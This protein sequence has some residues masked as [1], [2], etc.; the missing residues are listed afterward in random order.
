MKRKLTEM[1]IA[2]ELEQKFSK[3]R[4]FEMY[5]NQVS[6]GQRGSFSIDGFGEAA[7]AYFNKDVKNLTLPE[8]ALLAGMIQR[9]SYLS[10]Y[11]HPERALERRNLVLDSMVETGAITRDAGRPRQGHSA[12]AGAA[13]RRS[14]RRS[15]L[16]RPGEGPALQRSSAKTELNEQAC[17]IYTTI[18][19]DLQRAAAEAVDEGMKLVD[20][21]VIKR[22]TH[23]DQDRHRQGRQ[24]RNQ[25]RDRSHA[26]GG[27]GRHRSPHRRGAGAGRRP[28]L[29]HEPAEPRHRQ[30]PDGLHLQAFRLCRRGKHRA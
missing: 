12:E 27:A 8:A 4:I 7:R 17:R 23:K 6:M 3:Q 5:A 29:W 15:L 11:S 2:I 14:Q 1:L 24:D 20:E 21:Q 26:A 28:Q 16:R 18:D 9:P 19:P 25:G 22:R 30:A 10:P 13:E